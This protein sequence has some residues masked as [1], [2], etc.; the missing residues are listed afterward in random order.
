MINHYLYTNVTNPVWGNAAHTEIICTVT[1]PLLGKSV[2]FNAMA[3]DCMPHGVKLWTE[4]NAGK[5]GVIGAY[6]APGAV[7][8]KTTAPSTATP[9]NTAVAPAVAPSINQM[10]LDENAKSFSKNTL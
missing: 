8:A 2:P 3:T 1:F 7:A 5:Y 10:E 6:I 9:V 4:L